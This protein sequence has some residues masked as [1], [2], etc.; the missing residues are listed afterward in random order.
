MGSRPSHSLDPFDAAAMIPIGIPN[1]ILMAILY[2]KFVDS[3]AS[4]LKS[5]LIG[6][7]V[8]M[9][10]VIAG[11]LFELPIPILSLPS[12]YK[13]SGTGQSLGTK[14]YVKANGR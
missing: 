14:W 2:T 5:G 12:E 4:Y 11:Q 1:H 10:E 6:T 3:S 13:N 7:G 9:A 8:T